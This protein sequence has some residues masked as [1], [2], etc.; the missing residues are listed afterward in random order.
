MAIN[1][2]ATLQTAVANW[3]SRDDLTDRIPEFIALAEAHFNRAIRRPEMENSAT[4]TLSG[5]TLA[6]PADFLA[7]KS[8][9]LDDNPD[10]ELA[11]MP[12][13][14]L[15]DLYGSSTTGVPQVY[16]QADG[17]FYFA[18]APSDSY[19]LVMVYWQEIP[20]LSDSNTTNWLLDMAP[21][22]YLYGSLAHAAKYI[23][24]D[25]EFAASLTMA[26]RLIDELN[27]DGI[28][29]AAGGSPLTARPRKFV[30]AAGNGRGVW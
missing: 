17:C 16:T 7:V 19:S 24:D 10:R 2:Y 26:E 29:R 15:R 22:L 9:Y 20:A 1:T 6:F 18:P 21:D 14:Q 28:R 30:W 12:Y 11:Y 3:I 23:R 25:A 13:G 8:M 5:A 4:S 27:K